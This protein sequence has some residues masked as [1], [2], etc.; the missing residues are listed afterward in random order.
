MR[1]AKRI[2]AFA[3]AALAT[4][5]AGC[6]NLAV[7]E[8]K[9]METV[10]LAV[11]EEEYKKRDFLRFMDASNFLSEANGMAIPTD[12]AEL[13][14]YR[15]VVFSNYALFLKMKKEVE[16]QN[17]AIDQ[18][19][20]DTALS[21]AMDTAKTA[22][23]GDEA[24]QAKIAEYGKDEAEVKEKVRESLALQEYYTKFSELDNPDLSKEGEA[25]AAT[26]DGVPIPRSTM[27]YYV[28]YY[29]L[30]AYAQNT[31]PSLG[32]E[33]LYR[34]ALLSAARDQAYANY[35][36]SKGYE[37]TPEQISAALAESIDP[38][39]TMFGEETIKSFLSAYYISDAQHKAAKDLIGSS[40]AAQ[41]RVEDEVRATLNPTDED[42]L[43]YYKEN[44]ARYSF[45]TV[46][47][48]LPKDKNTALSNEILA[49][50]NAQPDK[51]ASYAAAY[52]KYATDERISEAAEYTI[53]RNG[54]TEDGAAMVSDFTDGVFA[55]QPGEA[56]IVETADYG[57]HVAYLVSKSEAPEAPADMGKVRED[58]VSS[59][60]ESPLST[61]LS[62]IYS[63]AKKKEASGYLVTPQ[64]TFDAVMQKK[65]SIKENEGAAAR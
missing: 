52:A 3:L 44:I 32:T 58:Y 29:N 16:G 18:A 34:T 60:M 36:K 28:I 33:D 10:V 23:E 22:F 25:L 41:K 13:V 11:G 62:D 24:Y 51:A 12:K 45:A 4:L 14:K 61:K 54:E 26:V 53:N 31:E 9:D 57:G 15:K 6:I 1:L 38:L 17:A 48:I 20:L 35:A 19:A 56:K 8:E 46:R 27:Y 5:G 21:S 43:A 63:A 37:A 64:E 55:M 49:E 50:V 7:N 47:H 65:Y 2:A 59:I 42:V 40:I 39:E 30:N